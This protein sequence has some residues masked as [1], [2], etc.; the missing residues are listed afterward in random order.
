MEIIIK[1]SHIKNKKFDAVINNKKTI[2]FGQ[3]G[4]SDMTQ[5]K[6]EDRKQR[7]LARHKNDNYKNPLYPSFYSTNILW[8][9]P[10]LTES[11]KDTNRRFK[12]VHIKLRS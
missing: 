1:P 6:N 3:A 12:N 9:K 10:T 7:Y 11:I 2:P 5:H 4:A 8:N